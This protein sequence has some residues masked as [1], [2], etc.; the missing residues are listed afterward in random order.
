MEGVSEEAAGPIGAREPETTSPPGV[1][2]GSALVGLSNGLWGADKEFDFSE[3]LHSIY[4]NQATVTAL[5]GRR[6]RQ[7]L[8]TH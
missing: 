5:F 7:T 4:T 6:D 8:L 3:R 2:S 1:C